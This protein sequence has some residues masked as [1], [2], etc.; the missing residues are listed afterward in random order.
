MGVIITF[1]YQVL[2]TYLRE[3]AEARVKHKAVVKSGNIHREIQILYF[4]KEVIWL[5]YFLYLAP[6]PH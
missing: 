4:G 3:H 5:I 1:E 6:T 2:S